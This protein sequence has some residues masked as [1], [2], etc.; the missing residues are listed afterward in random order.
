MRCKG[1]EKTVMQQAEM[2]CPPYSDCSIQKEKEIT[3]QDKLRYDAKRKYLH[4]HLEAT[5]DDER[6]CH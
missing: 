2:L 3:D 1:K 5:G 6:A 4:D